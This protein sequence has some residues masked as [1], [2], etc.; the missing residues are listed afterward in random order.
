MSVNLI[1]LD[2][3]K[4]LINSPEFCFLYL[5]TTSGRAWL[6][7]RILI[8][9]IDGFEEQSEVSNSFHII[10]P[11][12]IEINNIILGMKVRRTV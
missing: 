1:V 10:H 7:M 3:G 8:S 5:E 6:R 12:R 11:F 9:E 4:I 2:S